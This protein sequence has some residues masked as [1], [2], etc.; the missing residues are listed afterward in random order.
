M[1]VDMRYDIIS[2]NTVESLVEA[3]NRRYADVVG[4]KWIN[5]HGPP[6]RESGVWFQAIRIR[7]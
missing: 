3:V 4:E 1:T 6:F 5:L 2:A 7:L